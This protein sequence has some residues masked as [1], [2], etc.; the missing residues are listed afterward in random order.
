VNVKASLVRNTLW[1]GLV[2]LVGLGSGLVT[3]VLLAR[4][5][6]PERMGDFSYVTWAW[7]ALEAVATLGL[8][9]ATA[10]YT[11]DRIARGDVPGAWGFARHFLTRQLLATSLVV[12]GALLLVHGLAP[13]H[14]RVPLVIVTVALVPV[15]VES[16]HTHALYGAQRYDVTARLST[17]KMSLQIAV[18]AAVLALGGGLTAVFAG[19]AVTLVVSCALVRRAARR[20]YGS[21]A[22]AVP[23]G[24]R[25]EMRRYLVAVS[26][27]AVLDAIVWDRSEVFFL[28]LWGD[29]RDI[30]FYSLAFGLATRAMIV[31][32]IA[33]GALL[34]AF[35]ALH[36]GG[37]RADFEDVYRAALRY[38]ALAGALVTALVAALAPGIVVLLY[39]EP[40]RPAAGLLTAL[41][42]VALVSALRQVAWA[43]LPAVGDR[44]SAVAATLVGAVVNLALAAWLIRAHGT[45]G[46]VVA[47]AA[48]QL[49]ATTWVFVAMARRH[50]VR[51]PAWDLGRIA[52]AAGPAFLVTSVTG[53]GADDL[54]PGRLVLGAAAG[55]LTFLT[56][57][58]LSGVLGRR[59]WDAVRSRRPWR[60]AGIAPR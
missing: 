4:G 39:G 21:P 48:G 19:F 15:T 45:A 56:I 34:P 7:A 13:A 11:A 58:A 2:T 3:S 1:H 22:G 26:T 5:L 51:V 30:A 28:G 25:G 52:A 9:V 50:G 53:A 60:A 29:A 43:A 32:E 16:I 12:A 38:V 49:I 44:R 6:G 35:A 40:Y 46:A 17:L 18:V 42:A 36:G 33:A 24:A 31:P 23:A 37:Q 27:V 14:L 59:E 54:D 41:V 57:C 55:S 10:R 8:A 47:N 20:V